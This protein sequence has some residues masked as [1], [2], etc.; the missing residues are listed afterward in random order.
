MIYQGLIFT[1]H[2]WKYVMA[3]TK[4]V[5]E[6]LKRIAE[7]DLATKKTSKT[8]KTVEMVPAFY[9]QAECVHIYTRQLLPTKFASR[10]DHEITNEPMPLSHGIM[11][12]SPPQREH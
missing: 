8:K 12:M 3:Q 2:L 9:S 7:T 4:K 6:D 10:A 11:L 5:S 1:T